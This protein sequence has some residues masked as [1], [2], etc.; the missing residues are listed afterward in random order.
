MIVNEEMRKPLLV[1]ESESRADFYFCLIIKKI[2]PAIIN[3]ELIV[4]ISLPSG[5]DPSILL[6]M[7]LR[8]A[9]VGARSRVPCLFGYI[10]VGP[11]I[12]FLVWEMTIKTSTI[13]RSQVSRQ[14][15]D[16]FVSGKLDVFQSAGFY[17]T[18]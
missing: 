13:E 1:D 17:K 16:M 9:Q 15:E 2:P 3:R 10:F 4:P 18:C 8:G 5:V 11:D 12:G 6:D 14:P 7:S